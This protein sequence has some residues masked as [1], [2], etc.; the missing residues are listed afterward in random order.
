MPILFYNKELKTMYDKTFVKCFRNGFVDPVKKVLDNN[1]MEEVKETTEFRKAL[2]SGEIKSLYEF[3][4]TDFPVDSTYKKAFELVKEYMTEQ[5]S[6][7][8]CMIIWMHERLLLRVLRY[9]LDYGLD[10]YV[11]AALNNGAESL[12]EHDEYT[13]FRIRQMKQKEELPRFIEQR[14]VESARMRMMLA[15]ISS[16]TEDF[17]YLDDI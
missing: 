7:Y 15:H 14:L 10:S 17:Q 6:L 5:P 3:W 2:D 1:F 9:G 11:Y 4:R 16:Q 13:M 12:A 8:N